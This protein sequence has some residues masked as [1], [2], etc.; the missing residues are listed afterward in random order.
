SLSGAGAFLCF[1]WCRLSLLA[2]RLSLSVGAV[3]G[4]SLSLALGGSLDRLAHYVV[5]VDSLERELAQ[6]AFAFSIHADDLPG[7]QLAKQD[8]L[9]QRVLD[10]ALQGTAQRPGTQHGVVALLGEQLLGSHREL[11]T[12]VLVAHA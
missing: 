7:D 11:H 8:L 12:H 1:Q 3:L 6:D 4:C 5:L 9:A 2:A 10:L